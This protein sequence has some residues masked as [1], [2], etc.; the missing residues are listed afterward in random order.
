MAHDVFISY[1]SKD[2]SVADAVCAGLE[3]NGVR[4]WIAPRDILPGTAWSES[5]V[6]AIRDSKVMVIIFS[7]NSNQSS[8]VAREVERAIAKDVIIIPFRIENITPSEKMEYFLGTEHW[9]DALTPPLE[10]HIRKLIYSIQLLIT[11]KG[12]PLPVPPPPPDPIHPRA[13]RVGPFSIAQAGLIAFGGIVA[14]A[15]LLIAGFFG[16]QLLQGKFSPALTATTLSNLAP[17]ASETDAAPVSVSEPTAGVPSAPVPTAQPL[18]TGS[19][20]QPASDLPRKVNTCVVYPGDPKSILCGTGNNGSG[21]GVYKSEDGGLTWQSRSNGLP[22]S[23]ILS[24]AIGSNSAGTIYALSYERLYVSADDG[25]TWQ[26]QGKPEGIYGSDLRLVVSQGENPQLYVH[27]PGTGIM[28]STDGGQNWQFVNAGLPEDSDGQ[29]HVYS[30]AVDPLSP[31]T[32]Y[33]GTGSPSGMGQGVYKSL[34]GGQ[35]WAPSNQGMI[36]YG[37]PSLA[38][39]PLQPQTVYAAAS[40]AKLFKSQDGGATWTPLNLPVEDYATLSSV[41]LDPQKPER[42]YLLVDGQGL[43][44]SPDAGETWQ[45]IGKPVELDYPSFLTVTIL[46]ADSPSFFTG[47]REDG[48][49]LYGEEIAKPQA[50]PTALPSV[51]PAGAEF[52]PSGTWQ[53]AG[54]LPRQINGLAV[55]PTS[56]ATL[57]AATGFSGAGSGV[58]KSTD[59]GL[60]W[61]SA[62]GGLPPEDILD[63]AMSVGETPTL[64]AVTSTQIFASVDGAGSWTNRGDLPT[65]N[66]WSRN[67]IPSLVEAQTVFVLADGYDLIRSYDGGQSWEQLKDGLPLDSSGETHLLSLGLHPSDPNLLYVGTGDASGNGHGVYR[68][69]DGGKSWSPL[70]QGMIDRRI[71]GLSIDPTHPETIYAVDADS[72][73]YKSLDAGEHWGVVHYPDE[74]AWVNVISMASDPRTPQV[75][76]LFCDTIGL[77]VS[78]DGGVHWQLP[79]KPASIDYPS[80]TASAVQFTT[81]PVVVMGIRDNG[82]WRQGGE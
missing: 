79:G 35:T 12:Q 28:R 56:P 63:V 77:M 15:T 80:I 48:G 8:Q 19:S 40:P 45:M 82:V 4:C 29:A 18:P 75:I 3:N 36:D 17:Q 50:Q 54:G 34:D 72:T 57:Y 20:W 21:S 37:I 33:A 51:E 76:Y 68:S 58:Y 52:L 60:S 66:S 31:L 2:K 74:S 26:A 14:L 71:I 5:I 78:A 49:W 67:I 61:S 24:V 38:I 44:Y 23:D 59:N 55:D 1:S 11:G 62:S 73:L 13:A 10:A 32:L 6:N 81:P 47:T 25:Q 7:A 43:L 53:E 27:A 46:S 42:V 65:I 69:A 39:D 9:L 70:N 22:T 64:Y 30:V 16:W 41:S